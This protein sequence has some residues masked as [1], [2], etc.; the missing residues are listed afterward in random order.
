MLKANIFTKLDAYIDDI[1]EK[2]SKNYHT[3]SSYL[4]FPVKEMSMSF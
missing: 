1:E 3:L 4:Y 2:F